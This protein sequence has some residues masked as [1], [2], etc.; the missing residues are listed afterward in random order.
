MVLLDILYHKGFQI[1]AAHVDYQK[2]QDSYLDLETIK[3]YIKDK[4]IVLETFKVDK[5]A[6][7]A[8]NFQ[9]QARH[10]RYDF[11][12]SLKE[13]YATNILYVAHHKDDFL[14]TY[15][16]QKQRKGLYNYYGIAPITTYQ[17]LTVIRPL[18]N[19]YKKDIEDYATKNNIPYHQ[20]S[21]NLTLDYTRNKLRYQ[22]SLETKATKGKLYKEA[23]S[24]NMQIVQDAMF[25]QRQQA[26]YYKV[27]DFKKWDQNLKRK[28]LFKIMKK[29][30]VSTKELDEIIR[31]IEISNSLCKTFL[32]TTI[33]LSYGI[34]FML[35]SLDLSNDYLVKN[36]DD[37]NKV[38]KEFKDKYNFDII[39]KRQ[40]FPYYIKVVNETEYTHLISDKTK[41]KKR[42]KSRKIP[43]FLQKQLPV[44]VKDDQIIG[45]AFN[46]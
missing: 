22:L 20:D 40:N 14:E 5:N 29:Y 36:I 30:S 35:C 3:T 46:Y 38:K 44:I 11:F 43:S 31:Q 34:I 9:A 4:D 33:I 19:L 18:L 21:S 26:H 8:Q 27:D 39:V 10:I 16:F 17:D 12:L 13:K 37:Y 25:L 42:L 2:R 1:V 24:K 7:T 32:D 15:L 28:W 45:W 41:H 23:M 6:Y